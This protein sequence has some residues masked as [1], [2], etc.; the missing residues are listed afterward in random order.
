M[1]K[2]QVKNMKL[3]GEQINSGTLRLS[4][5]TNLLEF[6]LKYKTTKRL[7]LKYF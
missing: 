6:N 7:V 3:F 1:T 2:K 4:M 5:L